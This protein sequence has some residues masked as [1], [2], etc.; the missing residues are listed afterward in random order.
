MSYDIYLYE[1]GTDKVVQ[2]DDEHDLAGGTYC[3]GGTHEA[4]LNITYNYASH[5]RK[6]LGENGI[7]TIY[8]MTAAE[9]MPLIEN[10][11]AQL[12][13]DVS[14]RYWDSTEGNA[15]AALQDLLTLA[16]MRPDAVWNGD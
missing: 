16:R 13:D 8:G 11:I 7:R 15:K 3:V 6:V 14:E 2:F 9:S 5:F 12:G 10:A 4:W 1:P